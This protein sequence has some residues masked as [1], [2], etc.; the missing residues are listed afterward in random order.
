MQLS[1]P[2]TLC[3]AEVKYAV[4]ISIC[5]NAVKSILQKH[6]IQVFHAHMIECIKQLC[7][8]GALPHVKSNRKRRGASGKNLSVR[9]ST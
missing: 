8:A 4:I 9:S 6:P 1:Y 7:Q 3:T 5:A 2:R